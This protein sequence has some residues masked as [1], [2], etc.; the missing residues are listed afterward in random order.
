MEIRPN[1]QVTPFSHQ[2]YTQQYTGRH[3]KIMNTMF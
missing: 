1:H 3:K 2:Q